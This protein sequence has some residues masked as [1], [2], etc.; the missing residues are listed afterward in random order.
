MVVE[1]LSDNIALKL[2][3]GF[4]GHAQSLGSQSCQP[5][6]C[7]CPE[8]GLVTKGQDPQALGPMEEREVVM[9]NIN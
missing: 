9:V 8:S 4:Q 2:H 1:S 7:R 3:C 6:L 5:G